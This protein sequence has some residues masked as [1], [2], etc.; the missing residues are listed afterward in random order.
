LFGHL[1]NFIDAPAVV[2]L[3]VVVAW[4][5]LFDILYSLLVY[6]GNHFIREKQVE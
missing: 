2:V 3:V 5:C 6:V 4:F 1:A